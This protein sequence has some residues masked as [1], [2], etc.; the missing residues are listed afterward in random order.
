MNGCKNIQYLSICII[1]I[2]TICHI[3]VTYTQMAQSLKD[4][5]QVKYHVEFL[6]SKKI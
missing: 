2:M 5:F 1:I 3:F 4:N 6:N